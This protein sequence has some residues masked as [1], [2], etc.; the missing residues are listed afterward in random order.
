MRAPLQAVL[1]SQPVA[2]QADV[3]WVPP[4]EPVF[5]IRKLKD[6]RPP[7]PAA[8][9]ETLARLPVHNA[10]P[11]GFD[12]AVDGFEAWVKLLLLDAMQRLGFFTHP[13]QVRH[14]CYPLF[15]PSVVPGEPS[16]RRHSGRTSH[17][18]IAFPLEVSLAAGIVSHLPLSRQA[19]CWCHCMSWVKERSLCFDYQCW[20]SRL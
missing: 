1:A 13:G 16:S 17:V 8:F 6:A 10:L 12:A 3:G 7:V 20:S 4:L 9:S 18:D 19:L 14:S 5:S 15:I 11:E 2:A